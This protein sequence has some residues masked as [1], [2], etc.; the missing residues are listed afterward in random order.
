MTSHDRL[1]INS[2][3]LPTT[4]APPAEK[5]PTMHGRSWD[6]GPAA[7]LSVPHRL[8]GERSPP[9]ATTTTRGSTS[10]T[11]A[12]S[13]LGRDIGIPLAPQGQGGGFAQGDGLWIRSHGP[14]TTAMDDV[15]ST[16]TMSLPVDCMFR[17]PQRRP[18]SVVAVN[19]W[20][21]PRRRNQMS[22][23]P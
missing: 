20:I 1:E 16:T 10:T 23:Q 2:S 6:S 19:E 15:R 14:R 11:A 18:E 13:C 12:W 4:D 9:V 21:V 17:I 5:P 7:Q 3:G 22:Q 8:C